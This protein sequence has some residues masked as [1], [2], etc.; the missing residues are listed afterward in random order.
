MS[1]YGPTQ[2]VMST[3]SAIPKTAKALKFDTKNDAKEERK[4]DKLAAEA[5]AFLLSN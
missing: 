5:Q 2:S 4:L 1:M 3:S